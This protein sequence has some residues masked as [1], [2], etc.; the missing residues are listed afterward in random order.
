MNNQELQ[1]NLIKKLDSGEVVFYT[2]GK[3][4]YLSEWKGGEMP[5][6]ISEMVYLAEMNQIEGRVGWTYDT[7]KND[8]LKEK[9]Y[10]EKGLDKC[11]VKD[12][13]NKIYRTENDYKKVKIPCQD[14]H[15]RMICLE[16]SKKYEK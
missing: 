11:W 9:F 8:K 14:K 5:T 15:T 1:F 2:N 4:F 12:C 3:E 13:P 16:C 6:N 7:R 10:K